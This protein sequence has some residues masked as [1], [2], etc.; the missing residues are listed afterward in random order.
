MLTVILNVW[1]IKIMKPKH[2]KP[3]TTETVKVLTHR[4]AVDN[5][6]ANYVKGLS[7]AKIVNEYIKDH[8]NG[9]M[10]STAI[11]DVRHIIKQIRSYYRGLK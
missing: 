7:E 11:K 1:G 5:A 4:K 10:L 2:F 6:I 9:M 3:K 8:N